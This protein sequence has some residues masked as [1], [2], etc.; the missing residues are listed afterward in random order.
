M[1]VLLSLCIYLFRCFVFL[2][3]VFCL[4]L[5]FFMYVGRSFVISFF[6][7]LCLAFPQCVRLYL[8]RVFVIYLVRSFL[9]RFV[10]FPMYACLS[11]LMYSYI[12][13][14]L[15]FFRGSS[16]YF[17]RSFCFLYICMYIRLKFVSSLFMS[18]VV[19]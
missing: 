3:N 5:S 17:F 9:T 10:V 6:I 1:Y 2:I 18:V 16:L 7:Y 11:S 12:P 8:F 4:W 19:R 15:S 13:L 14:F